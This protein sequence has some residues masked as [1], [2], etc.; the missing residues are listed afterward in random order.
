MEKLIAVVTGGTRGIGLGIAASLLKRGASVALT[1]HRDQIAATKA[2]EYLGA[3]LKKDRQVIALK[4]DNADPDAVGENY[5]RLSETLGKVNVLVNNAGIMSQR[6][7]EALR[8]SDWNAEQLETLVRPCSTKKLL[9]YELDTQ[10]CTRL[11][12]TF[13]I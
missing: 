10:L 8:V 5:R 9:I 12:W 2:A 6:S 4:C 3:Y 7:F 11:P 13:M 1:Y